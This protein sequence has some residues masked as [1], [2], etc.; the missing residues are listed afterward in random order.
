M[1]TRCDQEARRLDLRRTWWTASSARPG[2]TSCGWPTHLCA[3]GDRVLYLAVVLDAWSR[4]IVGWSMTNHLRTKLVLDP[5]E[6][7]VD[8]R[9]P[10]DV[11]H[12]STRVAK[13]IRIVWQT[14]CRSSR[15]AFNG[16][17]R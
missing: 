14:L 1:T 3:D 16:L 10:T 4:K 2:R 7:A 11:M 12:H 5:M 6:A 13:R 8:Q 9:R 17:G 15:A